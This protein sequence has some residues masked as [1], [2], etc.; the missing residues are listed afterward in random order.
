MATAAVALRL[1]WSAPLQLLGL[2]S[3]DYELAVSAL[4]KAAEDEASVEQQRIQALAR[5]IANEL[6]VPLMRGLAAIQKTIARRPT[7]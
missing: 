3:E 2:A 4:N 6:G 1:G 7:L 5:A